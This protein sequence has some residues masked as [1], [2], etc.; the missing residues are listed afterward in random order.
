MV[1]LL[2]I[3]IIGVNYILPISIFC[4]S[5]NYIF[6]K[7]NKERIE[8]ELYYELEMA[9]IDSSDNQTDSEQDNETDSDQDSE[10]YNVN[11]SINDEINNEVELIENNDNMVE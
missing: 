9:N 10:P 5:K 8:R 1:T 3:L 7:F 6:P 2:F 4:I 11:I